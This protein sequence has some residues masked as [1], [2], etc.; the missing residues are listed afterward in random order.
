MKTFLSARC[1][2]ATIHAMWNG[3]FVCM[4]ALLLTTFSPFA[5]AQQLSGKD[6]T[7]RGLATHPQVFDG[8][9]IKVKG[10]ITFGWEGDNFLLDLPNSQNANLK[11]QFESKPRLWFYGNEGEINKAWE[12]YQKLWSKGSGFASGTFT[13]YFHF[14]PSAKGRMK[15]VFDPGPFQLEVV[16]VSDIGVHNEQ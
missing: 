16:T 11:R 1:N 7:V 4:V 9:L 8:Q 6:V 12:A 3:S 13:G 15:D 10:L 5:G 2:A 14:V